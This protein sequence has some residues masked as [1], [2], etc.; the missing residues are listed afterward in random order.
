MMTSENIN[1]V[2]REIFARLLAS[3]NITVEHRAN[4][5]SAAFDVKNRV[6]LLPV[7]KNISE[8]VYDLF[9]AHECSHALNTE[10]A[11][12][13]KVVQKVK[14]TGDK[15]YH[16]IFNC[17]E[18]ARIEKLIKRRFP[19]LAK[20]FFHGY[21]ELVEKD[22][23]GIRGKDVNQMHLIDRINLYFK[24][25]SILVNIPFSE[26]EKQFVEDIKVAETMD[27]V[28]DIT[29][30][31]YE[32]FKQEQQDKQQGNEQE[33]SEESEEG[34]EGEGSASDEDSEEGEED[35]ESNGSSSQGQ[36]EEDEEDEEGEEGS[37]DSDSD[38][39][40]EEGEDDGEGSESDDDEDGDEDGQG[41]QSKEMPKQQ[42]NP[43][44]KAP[45]SQP[46]S[47]VKKTEEAASKTPDQ[48]PVAAAVNNTAKDGF[49]PELGSTLQA[50]EDNK[51]KMIEYSTDKYNQINYAVLPKNIELDRII[52]GYKEVH[53][54]IKAH[55]ACTP[56]YE[57][58]YYSDNRKE[59]NQL[60]V[61]KKEFLKF[62]QENMSIISYLTKEFEMKKAA[63]DYKRTSLSRTG[64]INTNKLHAYKFVDDLFLKKE[65]H[66]EGKNHGLVMFID[67][68]SSMSS[69]IADTYR[70]LM[71]L[72]L[73][74]KK[75]NIPFEVY[76]FF[77][78]RCDNAVNRRLQ[79][80]ACAGQSVRRVQVDASFELR[81]YFSSKMTAMEFN[82]ACINIQALINY[83]ESAR[84]SDSSLRN[85]R[86]TLPGEESLNST[87]LNS[88]ILCA[89]Q[90]I[91]N[92]RKA[93]SLQKVNAIFLTDGDS[94]QLYMVDGSGHSYYSHGNTILRDSTSKKEVKVGSGR[95]AD[96]AALYKLLRDQT[97]A[98]IL[99]FY[100]ISGRKYAIRNYLSNV[101]NE[102][103]NNK[104][105]FDADAE[106]KKFQK[107]GNLVMRDC[108]GY[109][110]L[111][112]TKSESLEILNADLEIDAS[113]TNRTI[114][115]KFG[116]S[117]R[118][119]V[120][121]RV[122][123]SSFIDQIC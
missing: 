48:R 112:V 59:L 77:D 38:E 89:S 21:N 33:E 41:N 120:K 83:Y 47:S 63:D 67:G 7:F 43:E 65:V 36:D 111:Y 79:Y 39:D 15:T 9:V 76:G 53:S 118:G 78:G 105:S 20:Y 96:T 2:S 31:L 26:E 108:F 102:L 104:K 72:V 22:F 98:N 86:L 17:I 42:E 34:Q 24:V 115:K 3:E 56:G 116:S 75:V 68:S 57:G 82:D 14:E 92:F 49:K 87:P 114:A 4:I 60:D 91:N 55:Y 44:K 97:G 23:F 12:M 18:D 74:C 45:Q 70:Q 84:S 52:R 95:W 51:R 121:N 61:A 100:I 107:D 10:R 81:N 71:V 80:G 29:D 73:F 117:L 37:E 6:L 25:G 1:C 122:I 113:A 110:E 99:G 5:Q 46:D 54:Q 28:I 19:G 8:N 35:S 11:Y 101:R 64:S 27:Q 90:I 58:G 69:I 93:Y 106:Y 50:E 40:E 32:M 94:N 16:M 88:S 66:V 85:Y 62:K 109:D 103:S 123:L 13:D 30:R 119:K